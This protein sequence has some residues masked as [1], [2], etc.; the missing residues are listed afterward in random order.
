[1]NK[2]YKLY[3]DAG[4]G[5]VVITQN[6]IIQRFCISLNNVSDA[7]YNF[8]TYNHNFRMD[9]DMSR[10]CIIHVLPRTSIYVPPTIYIECISNT[11]RHIFKR[12]CK[13]YFLKYKTLPLL[14][15]IY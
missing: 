10:Y 8:P 5:I 9:I 4:I 11:W 7:I 13:L 2:K 15:S 3:R 1:M 14:S 12:I 6:S